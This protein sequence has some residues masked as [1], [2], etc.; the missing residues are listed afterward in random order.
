MDCLLVGI[1]LEVGA[2]L[3]DDA[4]G[5]GVV[6]DVDDSLM[7]ANVQAPAA[8]IAFCTSSRLGELPD[9]VMT[10]ASFTLYISAPPRQ[11]VTATNATQ[12][13]NSTVCIR[14]I[15]FSSFCLYRIRPQADDS[16]CG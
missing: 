4:V 16:R 8:T 3:V 12:K 7:A 13:Y 6:Q 11:P 15:T 2:V 14:F 5:F 9:A 1:V 10:G